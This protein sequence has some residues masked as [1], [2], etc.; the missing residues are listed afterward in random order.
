MVRYF[1][2]YVRKGQRRVPFV[3]KAIN[4]AKKSSFKKKVLSVMRGQ[5]ETKQAFTTVPYTL[6]NSGCNGQSDCLRLIPNTVQGVSDNGRIGDQIRPQSLTI[7]GILQM[8]PQGATQGDSVRKIAA[9]VMIVS[10]KHFNSWATAY[11]NATSW[12]PLL[13]KKGGTVSGYTGLMSDIYAPINTDVITCHYNKVHFFS[14]S[15]YFAVGGATAG[16]VPFSQDKL[17]HFFKK[18]IKF[19]KTRLFKY[20]TSVDSGLTPTASGAYIMLVGYTIIDGADV[21]DTA[22]SRITIQADCILNYEDA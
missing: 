1:R 13:L 10:P 5:L 11:A 14:Q 3:K 15:S 8:L 17:V 7:R 12:L 6:Q 9:R 19:G 22:T 18:T 16:M 21:P 20:D 4:K 2:R